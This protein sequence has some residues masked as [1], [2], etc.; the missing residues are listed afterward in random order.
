MDL[1]NRM[2]DVVLEMM[3]N[4]QH[5]YE[6]GPDRLRDC[7][8]GNVNTNHMLFIASGAFHSVKPSD[9]MPELQVRRAPRHLLPAKGYLACK[10]D[11]S[12]K[13]AFKSPLKRL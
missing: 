11:R 6:A 2:M 8:A 5:G 13:I 7:F 1:Y 12:L 4:P 3:D 10:L 9:L